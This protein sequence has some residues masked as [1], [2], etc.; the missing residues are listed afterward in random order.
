MVGLAPSRLR[1]LARER[2]DGD[3]S[4]LPEASFYA[5]PNEQDATSV[6]LSVIELGGSTPIIVAGLFH[7]AVPAGW[8]IHGRLALGERS[9]RL[10]WPECIGRVSLLVAGL[11]APPKHGFWMPDFDGVSVYA[12]CL[13]RNA[14]SRRAS[15][16]V[17]ARLRRLRETDPPV[18]VALPLLITAQSHDRRVTHNPPQHR[19]FPHVPGY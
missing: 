19:S 14:R 1:E 12:Q 6:E 11:S 2:P 9:L 8:P 13:R 17:E 10:L 18:V 7:E 5:P 4:G 16:A 3:L 15:V